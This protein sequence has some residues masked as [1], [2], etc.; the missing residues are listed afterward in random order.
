[1]LVLRGG[2]NESHLWGLGPLSHTPYFPCTFFQPKTW[3]DHTTDHDVVMPVVLRPGMGWDHEWPQSFSDTVL[4]L[5]IVTEALVSPT[6]VNCRTSV[7]TCR[8][9]SADFLYPPSR[10]I[11]GDKGLRRSGLAFVPPSPLVL[12]VALWW[13]RRRMP[14]LPKI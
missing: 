4:V 14:V 2:G 7:R 13:P 6:V 5:C 8:A 3:K 9:Y 11:S 10:G 12:P 1:M